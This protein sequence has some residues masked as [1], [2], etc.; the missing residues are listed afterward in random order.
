MLELAGKKAVF[1]KILINLTDERG[2]DF[3]FF[4]C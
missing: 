4:T 3:V 2:S 1:V